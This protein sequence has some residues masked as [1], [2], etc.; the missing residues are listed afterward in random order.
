MHLPIWQ[1]DMH[2]PHG[3]KAPTAHAFLVQQTYKIIAIHTVWIGTKKLMQG[4]RSDACGLYHS[5]L[6]VDYFP[7]LHFLHSFHAGASVLRP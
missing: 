4:I 3:P 6:I 1:Y 5:T 2:K 7:W